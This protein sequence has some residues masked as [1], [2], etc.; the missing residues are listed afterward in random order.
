M[1]PEI[2]LGFS[3]CTLK[4]CAYLI[5]DW[6]QRVQDLSLSIVWSENYTSSIKLNDNDMAF[7]YNLIISRNYWVNL[8]ETL[9]SSQ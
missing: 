1:K 4:L 8:F 3:M 7:K 5:L 9:T 6:W 2:S